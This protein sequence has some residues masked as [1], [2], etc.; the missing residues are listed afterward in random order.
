M[1]TE[2]IGVVGAGVMGCGLSQ[3]LAQTGHRVV[4]VDKSDGVLEKA[5]QEIRAGVRTA[6]L[7]G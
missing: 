4:L 5:K 7:L 2:T 6:A 1:L 3:T